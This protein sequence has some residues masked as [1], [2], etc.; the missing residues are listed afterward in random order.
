MG[1]S[2]AGKGAITA[3]NLT[4]DAN[5]KIAVEGDKVSVTGLHVTGNGYSGVVGTRRVRLKNG[6]VSGNGAQASPFSSAST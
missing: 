4:A 6:V 1:P 5:G 2:G 3:K